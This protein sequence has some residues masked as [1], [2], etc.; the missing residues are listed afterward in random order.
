MSKQRCISFSL[1]SIYSVGNISC[2]PTQS[3]QVEVGYCDAQGQYPG[4]SDLGFDTA[5]QKF[6]RGYQLADSNGRVQLVTIYPCWYLGGAVHIHFRIRTQAV[7][8]FSSFRQ[9]KLPKMLA[10]VLFISGKIAHYCPRI[11]HFH[12]SFFYATRAG[13]LQEYYRQPV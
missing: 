7:T 1:H 8:C 9:P 4:V 10:S 5:G 12:R 3:A 11:A 6:L 2:T 13:F